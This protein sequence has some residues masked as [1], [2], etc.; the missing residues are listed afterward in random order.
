MQDKEWGGGGKSEK[1]GNA[2]ER[3]SFFS[4]AKFFFCG[5]IN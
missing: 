1:E 5:T 2:N 4:F 3:F